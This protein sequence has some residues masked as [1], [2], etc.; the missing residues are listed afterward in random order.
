MARAF[1]KDTAV[2]AYFRLFFLLWF[3]LKEREKEREREREI[4]LCNS[5]IAK[6]D[7]NS[8]SGILTL[9]HFG[10]VSSMLAHI[11]RCS[12]VQIVQSSVIL[13][14]ALAQTPLSF[15]SPWRFLSFFYRW[16]AMSRLFRIFFFFSGGFQT[17]EGCENVGGGIKKKGIRKLSLTKVILSKCSSSPVNYLR[18]GLA[19]I[20]SS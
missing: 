18:D 1:R 16:A 19:L 11:Y 4:M 12:I 6:E 10:G 13:M 2:E 3:S 7:K 8:K 20:S 17:A 5:P 15:N 14:L 9:T